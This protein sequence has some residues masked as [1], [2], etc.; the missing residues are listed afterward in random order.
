[1][2]EFQRDKEGN[3]DCTDRADQA[4]LNMEFPIRV[5][6]SIRVI[7]DASP[8]PLLSAGSA[9]RGGSSALK[10]AKLQLS[11]LCAGQKSPILRIAPAG[12][13]FAP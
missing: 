8:L 9:A 7:R 13:G 12:T 2:P 10:W 4:D 11:G 6:R 5:I 3:A 1:M